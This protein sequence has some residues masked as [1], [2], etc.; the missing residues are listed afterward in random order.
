MQ[1]GHLCQT[2]LALGVVY[3]AHDNTTPNEKQAG[4]SPCKQ[5]LAGGTKTNIAKHNNRICK[6]SYNYFKN[7]WSMSLH[8]NTHAL[9]MTH[10][11]YIYWLNRCKLFIYDLSG[12][13]TGRITSRAGCRAFIL[14]TLI[15]YESQFWAD[16]RIRV[17]YFE[18]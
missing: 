8:K 10:F 3:Q 13:I 12:R 4:C 17:K 15:T 9:V 16:K 11:Q 5:I 2:S 7:E 18:I 6:H 14:T 1:F